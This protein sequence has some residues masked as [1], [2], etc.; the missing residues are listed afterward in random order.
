MH[1][2]CTMGQI[3]KWDE[4]KENYIRNKKVVEYIQKKYAITELYD[5]TKIIFAQ[6]CS[7]V[8]YLH[9]HDITNRDIKVDN[10]LCTETENKL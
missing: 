4:L 10:I 9:D 6:V 3:M 1:E 7:A 2:L 5:V 8:K